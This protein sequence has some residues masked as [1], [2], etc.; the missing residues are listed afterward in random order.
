MV[1]LQKSS[2]TEGFG[3]FSFLF[4]MKNIPVNEEDNRKDDA[5]VKER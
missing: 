4:R 1:A 5:M 3:P 2:W